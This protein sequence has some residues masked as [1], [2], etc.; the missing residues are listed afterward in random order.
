MDGGGWWAVGGEFPRPSTRL[1]PPNTGGG[2]SRTRLVRR[3]PN[4]RNSGLPSVHSMRPC[5]GVAR[6]AYSKWER[7]AALTPAHVARIAAN[8]VRVLV[9]PSPKRVFSDAE[10]AEAGAI[11]TEDLS[12]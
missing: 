9:Q 6:E 11:I 4:G 8:G 5:L 1:P 12:P 10:Y 2:G 3:T 7:R